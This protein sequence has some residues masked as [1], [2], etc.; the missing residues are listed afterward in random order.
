[1]SQVCN[2][3]DNRK[4]RKKDVG[5]IILHCK[6]TKKDLAKLYESVM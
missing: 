1:M 4:C 6:K 5:N 2:T 3:N